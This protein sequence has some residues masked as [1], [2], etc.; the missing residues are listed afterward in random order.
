MKSTIFL[1]CLVLSAGITSIAQEKTIKDAN[2]EKRNVS[3]FHTI[4]VEDG[5][6]LYLT[7]SDE[8][9]VAVSAGRLEDRDKIKT[10]VENGVLRI[11]YNNNGLVITGWRNRY[12]RAYVSVK[13]LQELRA[14]GGSDAYAESGLTVKDFKLHTSGGSDFRGTV[15]ADNLELRAS[16]GSDIRISGKTINLRAISSGGSDIHGFDLIAEN[17]FI[18]SSGGSD[19]R[20]T[21][22]HE[23]GVE[24]SGGSDVDYKGNPVI[25]YKSSSGGGSVT[26]RN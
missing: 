4:R 6:D 24:A 5:I 15:N 14:S 7:Q 25:K 11:Y 3:G 20:I 13:T 9:A 22:T 21:V 16:G 8:E 17:A 23:L 19:A 12:L 10:I 26:K 2:V 1:F 18:T